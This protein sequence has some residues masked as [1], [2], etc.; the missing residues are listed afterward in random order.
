MTSPS[1]S[2]SYSILSYL[3][4]PSLSS[5]LSPEKKSK[6]ESSIK[7]LS[8]ALSLDLNDPST[9]AKYGGGPGLQ[10]IY[11]VFERTQKKMGGGQEVS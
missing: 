6:L 3:S 4:D 10:T 7:D 5:S 1:P 9:Q 11:Q 8:E 2:L